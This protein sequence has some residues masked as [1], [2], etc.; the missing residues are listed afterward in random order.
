MTDMPRQLVLDLPHRA[1]LGA[2]DFL[3]SR[4]NATAIAFIDRWPDWGRWPDW[5][6]A[7]AIVVGP[8]Q[9]GKSHLAH[10]WQMKSKAGLVAASSLSSAAIDLLAEHGALVVEDVDRGIGDEQVLFHLLNL[11]REHRQS[12]LLTSRRPAG[13]LEFAL[14]DLRSRLR[15]LPSIIIETPDEELLRALLVK[16]FADRQLMI[17]PH[18]IAHI[19]LHMER[20]AAA[21]TRIVH[22]IDR[23]ALA[24][25]RKV[26]RA[27]AAEVLAREKATLPDIDPEEIQP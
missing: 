16:L 26:T 27:L 1:A 20:S 24:A 18:V 4:S 15:A 13:E 11:V 22:A 9:A 8:R 21:A 23:Q 14:A 10:V 5:P 17:E 25:H 12:L 19:I 3:V 2:E 6:L 7:S